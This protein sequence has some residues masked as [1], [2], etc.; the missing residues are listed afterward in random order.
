MQHR[1]QNHFSAWNAFLQ[2]GMK[3]DPHTVDLNCLGLHHHLIGIPHLLQSLSL[4]HLLLGLLNLF[5]LLQ[6]LLSFLLQT[7]DGPLLVHL[8]L[9]LQIIHLLLNAGDQRVAPPLQ[10]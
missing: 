4:L 1:G 9:I 8:S 7:L 6:L 3:N 10:L 2:N 5:N